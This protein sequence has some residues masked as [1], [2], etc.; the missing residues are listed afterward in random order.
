MDDFTLIKVMCIAALYGGIKNTKVIHSDYDLNMNEELLI[1]FHELV[2]MFIIF[3]IFFEDRTYILF[4]LVVTTIIALMWFAMDRNCILILI[5]RETIP[6]TPE[7][8][9]KIYGTDSDKM[10][11]FIGTAGLAIAIDIY[12]LVKGS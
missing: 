5:K 3:G 7:D 2:T 12:K 6:Y 10:L 8:L 4:H 9:V 11:T 1:V